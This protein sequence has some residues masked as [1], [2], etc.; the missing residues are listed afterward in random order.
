MKLYEAILLSVAVS[1]LIIGIHQIM[2]GDVLN[3]Y[4][5]FMI[6][7]AALLGLKLWRTQTETSSAT[8]PAPKQTPNK[9]TSQP[10]RKKR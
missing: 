9:P 8:K 3:S 7:G 4:W 2:L 6:S 10:K 1:T 5:I